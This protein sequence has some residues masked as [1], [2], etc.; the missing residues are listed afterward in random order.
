VNIFKR[1]QKP[2]TLAFHE[3]H[4]IW[5]RLS[6]Y[7]GK[8]LLEVCKELYEAEDEF[9]KVC[10]IVY[11]SNIVTDFPSLSAFLLSKGLEQVGYPEY[12]DALNGN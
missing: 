4:E 1:K 10:K 2:R 6:V 9:A 5:L 12:K 3:I 7:R 8:T 11:G